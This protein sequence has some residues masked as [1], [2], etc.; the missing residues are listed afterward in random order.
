MYQ[1]SDHNK[2]YSTVMK[3]TF[4]PSP[5]TRKPTCKTIN[6]WFSYFR[7][8]CMEDAK[9]NVEKIGGEDD[10]VEMDETMCGKM[11]Y[12]KSEPEEK[13]ASVGRKSRKLGKCFMALCP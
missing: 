7:F 11:K 2:T 6:K 3:E 10:V 9:N 8:L 4:L 12:G 5:A 13:E 1:C